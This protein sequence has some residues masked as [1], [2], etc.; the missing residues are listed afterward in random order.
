MAKQE[1]IDQMYAFIASDEDGEG[2]IGMK[3]NENEWLPLVGADMARVESLKS[4][5]RSLSA[6]TGK[7]VI[8]VRFT[9]REELE[10]YGG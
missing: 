8:L 1:R 6:A 9:N 4:Y 10:V 2:V 3:V 5:A 7:K